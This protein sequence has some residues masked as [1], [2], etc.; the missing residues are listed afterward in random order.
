ML[1]YKYR[2]ALYQEASLSARLNFGHVDLRRPDMSGM[3]KLLPGKETGELRWW[4][5]Q[6]PGYLDEA[7]VGV[8]PRPRSQRPSHPGVK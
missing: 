8:C 4:L 6:P 2:R 5:G 3:P 1:L 7:A